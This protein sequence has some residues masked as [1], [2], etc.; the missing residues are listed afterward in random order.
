MKIYVKKH[1]YVVGVVWFSFVQITNWYRKNNFLSDYKTI[2]MGKTVNR[3]H[4]KCPTDVLK[5]HPTIFFMKI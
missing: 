5:Q 2:W 3:N 1:N 4:I